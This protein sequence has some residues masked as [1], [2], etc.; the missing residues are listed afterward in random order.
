MGIQKNATYKVHNGTDFD[1]INFKTIASQVKMSSGI[2]LENG[3]LNNKTTGYTNLPNGILIQWGYT[4]V[5]LSNQGGKT[6]TIQL[7]TTFN[8]DF[9]V[10]ANERDNSITSQGMFNVGSVKSSNGAISINV[11]DLAQAN[12]TGRVRVNWF[13][14]GY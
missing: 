8:N 10:I 1:E 13:A 3:F 11:Q 5:N 6:V 2:D 7:P 14:I 4:D 12:R 9:I